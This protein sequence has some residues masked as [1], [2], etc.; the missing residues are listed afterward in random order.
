VNTHAG[1]LTF[2]LG[3]TA[4]TAD[5]DFQVADGN[6]DAV[7]WVG[8]WPAWPARGLVV[9]GPPG[10]GKSH[11]L[12]VWQRRTGARMLDADTLP[13]ASGAP[14]MQ[15]DAA[16]AIDAADRIAGRASE[17][18][19]LHLYNRLVEADG[20]LLLTGREPP[21]RWPLQLPDLASRIRALPAV[22]L[23]PPDDALLAAVLV[24]LFADRQLTVSHDVVMLL[25]SR[26]ERS[27]AAAR[28]V[29]AALDAASLAEKR[30][31]SR[32]LVKKVLGDPGEA[33]GPQSR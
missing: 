8:R 17:E 9:Y 29:V 1:Q 5:D 25:L 22:A 21:G 3:H 2:E 7:A 24:K 13:P 6:R 11:L 14:V 23:A 16:V 28:E 10:S 26:I 30:P 18:A 32:G 31:V 33:R 15:R 19:L 20:W 27:F 12:A 4:S